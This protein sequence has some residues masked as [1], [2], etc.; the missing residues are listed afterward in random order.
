[1]HSSQKDYH[2]L[3]MDWKGRALK[4]EKQVKEFKPFDIRNMTFWCEQCKGYRKMLTDGD[5][6]CSDCHLVVMSYEL[7]K[8]EK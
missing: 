6:T 3:W 4:A 8:E 7:L 2:D 5:L 1:M